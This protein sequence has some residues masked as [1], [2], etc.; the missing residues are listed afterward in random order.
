MDYVAAPQAFG[1]KRFH[2]SKAYQSLPEASD[3]EWSDSFFE[4]E[5]GTVAVFDFDYLQIV[6]F[7]TKT[8]IVGTVVALGTIGLNVFLFAFLA[9]ESSIV[10]L[11]VAVAAQLAYLL[12]T[13]TPCFLRSNV[14]WAAYAQHVAITRDGIRFVQDRRKFWCGLPMCD[15]G[16][17][18]K[19]VPYDKITDC[20]VLEPA[21]AVCFCITRVLTIVNVDTA[22]SGREG[23]IHELQIAGLQDPRRFKQLVW[24]M[25]R[26]GT[27]YGSTA[28][29]APTTLEMT[30]RSMHD[31]TTTTGTA[32]GNTLERV[33][34]GESNSSVK[35][36]LRDIRSELRENN[37]LLKEVRATNQLVTGGAIT[38]EKGEMV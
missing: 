32:L 2:V 16:R 35:H 21:G 18:S 13:L 7:V 5:E 28:Y 8:A 36:L 19:T 6:D 20:D 31:V 24:A 12:V 15:Q 29:V 10:A 33:A 3:L 4:D 1:N 9:S 22:S 37:K 27:G 14:E 23:K 26:S 34:S 11:E 30:E 38:R 25:K 17:H